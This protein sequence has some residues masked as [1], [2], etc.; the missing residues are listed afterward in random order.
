MGNDLKSKA[1]RSDNSIGMALA[2]SAF[3]TFST[4]DLCSKLLGG[5][6]KPF[7]VALSGGV[8]GILL[9][10][11]LWKK[12]YTWRSMLPDQGAWGLWTLRAFCVFAATACAVTAFML[13]PMAEAMALMF[14]MPLVTNIMTVVVLCEKVPA[15]SWVVSLIGFAGI[16]TVE[17]HAL[18]TLT[19]GFG[20]ICAIGVSLAQTTN[21][22]VAR[23]LKNKTTDLSIYTAVLVGPILGNGVTLGITHD[24][25]MP[26]SLKIWLFLFGYG[27]LAA[28]AQF[29][30]MYAAQKVIAAK[31][32]LAQYSQLFWST[33]FGFLVFHEVPDAFGFAGLVIVLFSGILGAFLQNQE[34]RRSAVIVDPI[35]DPV[36]DF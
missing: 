26:S 20:E 29:I 7:E 27:F 22:M 33:M 24:F 5:V 1:V 28:C 31:V 18:D 6:L 25:V 19:L 13:L 14:L 16:L 10:P 23:G 12:G 34:E 36:A 9:I 11:F 17:H 35:V 32:T 21:I 2:L 30:L 4:S 8:F 3:L 15:S